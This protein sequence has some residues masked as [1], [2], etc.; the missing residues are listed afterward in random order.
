MDDT[1]NLNSQGH[2]PSWGKL[3]WLPFLLILLSCMAFLVWTWNREDLSRQHQNI[4]AAKAIVIGSALLVLW[5]LFVVWRWP[6]VRWSVIGFLVTVTV[7]LAATVR[8][9]GVT[10]DLIP[11]MEWRWKRSGLEEIQKPPVVTPLRTGVAEST[12]AYPQIL[13]P[14]RTGIIQGLVLNRDWSAHPPELVWRKEL[15]AAWSGFAILG[16]Y[17]VT[18]EQRGEE[19]M[20]ICYEL[21]SGNLLWAHGDKAHYSTTIAGEG[22]RATPTIVSNRV[23][24]LGATGILNCLDLFSGKKLW[25]RN[26]VEENGGKVNDWGVSCSPLVTEN[27]VVVSAG[28]GLKDAHWSLMTSKQAS[29]CGVGEMAELAIVRR[30]RHYLRVYSRY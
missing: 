28:G 1:D 21:G 24:T 16:D 3:W 8:I 25:T 4:E 18:Q 27:R 5:F 14:D 19:E 13:G 6:V 17:A 26:I 23:F 7:F 11:I 9:A 12:L 2:G 10:G 30:A 29:F 22:P 15:G 20:V